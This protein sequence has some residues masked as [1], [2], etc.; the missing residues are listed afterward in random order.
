MPAKD[1]AEAPDP[2]GYGIDTVEY[3]LDALE[4]EG[5]GPS[6]GVARAREAIRQ[7]REGGQGSA[8]ESVWD[9][10][11]ILESILDSISDGVVGIDR[12]GRCSFS[13]KA[14]TQILGI[15]PKNSSLR[16]WS[17]SQWCFVSDAGQAYVTAELPAVRALHGDEVENG[18]VFIRR[19]N[20]PDGVWV[21]IDARPLRDHQGVVK[22]SLCIIHDITEAKKREAELRD[23]N[24][25]LSMTIAELKSAQQQVIRQERLRAFGQM[26]SGVAHDFNNAL[27]VIQGI[28]ELLKCYP[29][30][31][32]DG[33]K[34]DRYLG[35][36]DTAA[37]DAGNVVRRLRKF[38]RGREE[39]EVR[40]L[41]CLNS[42]IEEALS[43][44]EP[45][46][47]GQAQAS[48][49]TIRVSTELDEIPRLAA[50]ES[51]LREALTNMIFNAV[52]AMPQGGEITIR[53][54]AEGEGVVLTISDT[55]TGMTDEV[56][57][58]CFDPFFTTKGPAGT[59]LGLAS[60]YGIIQRHGGTMDV[61]GEEGVGTSFTLR[62]PIGEEQEGEDSDHEPGRRCRPLNLLVVDDDPMVLDILRDLLAADGH[63][64]ETAADGREALEKFHMGW[65][66]LVLT[67]L[68]MPEMNG[69]KLA[70]AIKRI[71]PDKPVVLLTGFGDGITA[72]DTK[73]KD[74]DLVVGKPVTV[75]KLRKALALA[76]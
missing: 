16:D 45:R 55:G 28:T 29:D 39:N 73:P 75:S 37:R 51:E 12:D 47:R 64:F 42:L 62:L 56:R 30:Y 43:L 15:D 59:G 20:R 27:T 21:S 8:Q 46:W 54:T 36:I 11:G 58:H 61:D 76:E 33:E 71:V 60:V 72:S 65:Y 69:D 53:T 10:S 34:L 49:A 26:A 48:G 6:D 2:N 50:N 67:D 63:L 52:D 35:M 17:N 44:T 38:Y 31:L 32:E 41:V 4:Q 3:F 23:R 7:R 57:E 1:D 25:E 9:G 13:N 5:I 24:R 66:D 22:G 68:A 70:T 14:A 18:Q 19:P 74:V 40:Q